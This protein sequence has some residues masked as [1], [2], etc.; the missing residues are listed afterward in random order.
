MKSAIWTMFK[1]GHSGR[2]TVGITAG[3]AVAVVAAVVA[4]LVVVVGPSGGKDAAAGPLPVGDIV[5]MID[6]SGSMGPD[7]ADVKANVNTIATQLGASIDFQ[8]GL[9]GF[10]DGT[11]FGA[12]FSGGAHIHQALTPDVP[13]FSTAVAQLVASGGFEPGFDATVLGMS[14]AMGF[15]TDAAVCGIIITDEDAD[16]RTETKASALAALN[17]RSAIFL[18][19]VNPGFGNTANDY[20]PNV[21]SLSEATG[22][23]VF[24]ILAFRADPQPVLDSIIQLCVEFIEEQQ[25][26]CTP[27]PLPL[28]PGVRDPCQ[29]LTE[30]PEGPTST[31]PDGRITHTPTPST[32]TITPTPDTPTITPTQEVLTVCTPLPLPLPPGVRD[33]CP[34]ATETPEP[35]TSTP[36]PSRRR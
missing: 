31:P 17:G 1:R 28:P 4:L 10:G 20:G 24:D 22:G 18:G 33:P 11:H 21:G 6:E 23:Q 5:F 2:T 30:T 7:I 13:T 29:S 35:P 25:E 12:P 36:P 3:L 9:I 8:L 32:P 34:S 15:R 26:V 16:I 27:L 14:N 19:I